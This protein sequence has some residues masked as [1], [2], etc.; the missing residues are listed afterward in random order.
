MTLGK[1]RYSFMS[2]SIAYLFVC[3]AHVRS[4]GVGGRQCVGGSHWLSGIKQ[5]TLEA[6]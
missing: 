6:P 3:V 1:V 4:V 2:L 5:G